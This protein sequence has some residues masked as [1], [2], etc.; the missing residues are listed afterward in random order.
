MRQGPGDSEACRVVGIS[1][2]SGTRWRHGHTAI[3]KTGEIRKYPA[4]WRRKPAVVPARFLS[5]VERITIA[6][7]LHAGRSVRAIAR[8]AWP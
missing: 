3:T 5:D 8:G 1:L 4:I 7:L 2:G 6:D